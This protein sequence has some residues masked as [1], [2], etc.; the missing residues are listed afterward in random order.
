M[1][2]LSSFETCLPL[3]KREDILHPVK[4]F[5]KKLRVKSKVI[6]VKQ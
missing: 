1:H 4:N 5:E 6:A 3:K 2:S